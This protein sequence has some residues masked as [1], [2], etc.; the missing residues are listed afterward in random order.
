MKVCSRANLIFR[1]LTFDFFFVEFISF[2]KR[3]HAP[4]LNVTDFYFQKR[5]LVFIFFCGTRTLPIQFSQIDL[6]LSKKC[7]ELFL[8]LKEL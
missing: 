7:V 4:L 5:I 6:C 1:G 8:K 3:K 2:V